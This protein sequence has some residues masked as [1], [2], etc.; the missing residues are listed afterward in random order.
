[1]SHS[2]TVS[3]GSILLIFILLLSLPCR[4]R[5]QSIPLLRVARKI[6][7]EHPIDIIIG[8]EDIVGLLL[9][10]PTRKVDCRNLRAFLPE[11]HENMLCARFASRDG[12]YRGEF[13]Y[14]VSKSP[15]GAYLLE[16]DSDYLSYLNSLNA[17]L[18]G[19]S[20]WLAP[21]CGA[22]AGE[23]AARLPV[24]WGAVS[25][26]QHL[27]VFVNSRDN[28][29]RIVDDGASPNEQ[30]SRCV[31]L[32]GPQMSFNRQCDVPPASSKR[33][34]LRVQLFHGGQPVDETPLMVD[35]P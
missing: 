23:T 3:P 31:K 27:L 16:V 25:G 2:R 28:S 35:M 24:S 6:L 26:S 30:V 8:S 5:A 4:V 12:S 17:S 7:D 11:H 9:G 32:P 19:V 21:S 18:L 29:A 33:R 14:D 34:S 15:R 1:M 10:D 20:L 13:A 22:L